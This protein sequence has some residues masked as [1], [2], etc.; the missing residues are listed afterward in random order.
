MNTKLLT[1]TIFAFMT[2]LSSVPIVAYE[3]T[4]HA[5]MSGKASEKSVVSDAVF[6]GRLGIFQLRN[7]LG[8]NYFDLADATGNASI[9]TRLANN[10]EVSK[11]SAEFS[12]IEPNGTIGWLMRGTEIGE[13]LAHPRAGEDAAHV[14]HA[15]AG[16]GAFVGCLRHV[17]AR[18]YSD[19]TSILPLMS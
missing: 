16:E 9:A 3:L 19:E 14:E 10:F 7:A 4:T 2:L 18:R 13:E 6:L 15:Y 12:L 17:V 8:A 5:A 11:F 1:L